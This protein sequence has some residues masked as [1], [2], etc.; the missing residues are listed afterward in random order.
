MLPRTSSPTSRDLGFTRML[1]HERQGRELT[2]NVGAA[3][4][5]G[6]QL[7]EHIGANEDKVALGRVYMTS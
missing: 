4:S 7:E 5:A 2:R 3:Y 1:G 6:I